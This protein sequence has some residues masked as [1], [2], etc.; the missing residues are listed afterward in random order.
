MQ[1]VSDEELKRMGLE[2]A[3][4]EGARRELAEVAGG[5]GWKLEVFDGVEG[6]ELRGVVEGED[7]DGEGEG[8]G[9]ENGDGDGGEEEVGSE[10]VYKD[11]L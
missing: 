2:P 3:L 1:R 6:R 4:V 10:E 5:K 7:V 11:E 9:G 8:E